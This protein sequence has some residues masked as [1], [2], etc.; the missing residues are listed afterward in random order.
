MNVFRLNDAEIAFG[1]RKILDSQSLQ[2]D[3]GE[4]V[5]LIGRNGAG[6]STLLRVISGALNLDD[7]TRWINDERKAAYL[8]QSV[9]DGLEKTIYEVVVA[10]LG[11]LGDC[12]NRY[13]V[14]SK[15]ADFQQEKILNEFSELS[16]KIDHLGGWDVK[17]RVDKTLDELSLSGDSEMKNSSGGIRRRVMLAQALVSGPELLLLDEPTNHLDIDSIDQLQSTLLSLDTSLVMVSHDRALIDSVAT[18]I[19]EI[20]RGI[21]TSYPGNYQNYLE[22]KRK[23]ME[24]ELVHNKLFEKELAK[25]E[26]WI[27]EGIKARR[28]RNEGRVRR[29]E[30]MRLERSRRQDKQGNVKLSVEEGQRS[31]NIVFDLENVDFG[32]DEK[33]LTNFSSVVRRKDR[34]GIIGANGSGKSTLIRLMLGELEP[35]AGQVIRGTNLQVAYFD[36]QR[37]N[38]DPKKTVKDS[39]AD[40][41]EHVE[42]NGVRKHVVGYLG[43]FLFPPHYMNVSVSKLSGGEKNRLLLAKLFAKPANLLVLD[44]P[45]N[46]LDIETLELLEELLADFAGTILL[47]SHDRTFLDSVVTSTIVFD[48]EGCVREFVGGYSDWQRQASQS[49]REAK[50]LI[51]GSED[52]IREQVKKDSK[53][54]GFKE[55]RELEAMPELIGSLEELLA[56][57]NVEVSDPGFYKQEKTSVK[58]ILD[59]LEDTKD[60]IDE[61]YRRWEFLTE[62]NDEES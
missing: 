27:R 28:T 30:K 15:R 62:S 58:E 47:V 48:E 26:S 13:E 25:E 17:Y 29:L 46:D 40:R 9:P 24:E 31:G 52:K 42:V 34:V 7:G 1:D 33:I 4:R 35:Q 21:L 44:E 16:E 11:E 60:Q 22:R 12:L 14:L 41:N 8:D 5:I 2:I 45:T 50:T 37:D 38:L 57:L 23:E 55:Q 49:N 18:R 32:F 10:G 51:Q 56:R 20:D 39:V 43:D 19:V 54:L 6:K 61:A 36:Q 3:R 53:K 59:K